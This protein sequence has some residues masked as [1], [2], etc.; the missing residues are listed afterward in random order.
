[1][2]DADF[3]A[4]VP[5]PY[6]NDEALLAELSKA[7]PDTEIGRWIRKSVETGQVALVIS[8]TSLVFGP[9]WKKIYD[10]HVH[11]RLAAIAVSVKTAIQGKN[12]GAHRACRALAAD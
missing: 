12:G 9:M 6:Y 1:M 3:R 11:P 10:E 4:F 2:E 8:T 5:H 7:N